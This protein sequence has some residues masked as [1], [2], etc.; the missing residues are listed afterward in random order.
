MDPE[1]RVD[2]CVCFFL[3]EIVMVLVRTRC[4]EYK[5]KGKEKVVSVSTHD[6]DGVEEP[7]PTR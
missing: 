3:R 4:I 5:E 6:D 2:G 7:Q 1:D